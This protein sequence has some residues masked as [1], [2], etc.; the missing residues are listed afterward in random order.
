MS[1]W[2]FIEL[3][4]LCDL[5]KGK[6]G[7]MKAVSGKYTLVATGKERRTC[8]SYQLDTKAVC[9]PLVSSTGH[10]HAS[11][12]Y[13]HYQEGKFAL[14]TILVAV[15]PKDENVLNAQFLHLYLSRLKDSILVP[16]MTGAANVTLTVTKLKTVKV[17]LLPIEEQLRIVSL[18]NRM[19]N[20]QAELTDAISNQ[21]DL[22]KKL[23]QSIL[24]DAIEGKLTDSW[25]E[26]NPSAES[27]SIL[28]KKI[29]TEKEQLVKAKKIKKQ[30]ILSPINGAERPFDVPDSWE[31]CRLGDIFNS[32]IGGNS[33]LSSS[34]KEDGINQVLRLGN[35]RPYKLRLDAKPVFITN[36]L[37]DETLNAELKTNDLLIT[38]TGT[39]GKRDYCYTVLLEE[40]DFNNKRLFLNQRVGCF[41][42]NQNII[43]KF[44]DYALKSDT[45]LDNI[46]KTATGSANQANI[47]STALS[48]WSIP[49][50]QVEEQKAIVTKI[51]NLFKICDQLETQINSSKTNS[52]ILIQAVLKE[53]FEG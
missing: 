41:R 13:V 46:Y 31:W 11:L 36:S 39:R 37:A 21:Q 28:L 6:T 32:L 45:L 20:E 38:M 5:E 53:A 26:Q 43:P 25:R 2:D 50:P 33:Y 23:R 34:F 4:E 40:S 14:G 8:D 49:L 9:I 51:E 16:L 48:L 42:F 35:I 27:A 52:E 30:K 17:P 44:Y 10:G 12:K 22:L 19:D 15:I 3:S 18:F 1:K 29:K 47:G 24:Q 7:L